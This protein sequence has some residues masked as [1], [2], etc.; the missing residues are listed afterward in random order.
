MLTHVSVRGDFINAAI[1]CTDVN[2]AAVDPSAAEARFYIVSQISG[3]PALDTR[4]GV[5]GVVALSKQAGETGFWGAA[6]ETAGLG[7]NQYVVLF[8]AVIGGTASIA[9]DY[10]EIEEDMHLPG[11]V[12]NAV[13]A[14]SSDTLTVNAWLTDHGRTITDPI[15]CIFTLYNDAG[16]PVFSELFSDSPDANGVFRLTKTAPGLS[17][18]RSYYGKVVIYNGIG[19]YSSLIGLVTVE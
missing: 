9:V 17:H 2:G 10:L 5:N 12:A 6:V 7:P 4:I 15:D 16:A 18:D 3:S 14:N 1:A 19:L 11:C 8:K 13:Y